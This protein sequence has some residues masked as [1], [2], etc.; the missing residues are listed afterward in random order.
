MRAHEPYGGRCKFTCV[1]LAKVDQ[2]VLCNVVLQ[3]HVFR[4][5]SST[6]VCACALLKRR[7]VEF[8]VRTVVVEL[9]VNF[10]GRFDC[11]EVQEF[12][13]VCLKYTKES[14]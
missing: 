4:S 2:L 11:V 8:A 13:R 6:V 1:V 7:V 5:A 10:D 3:S 14:S 12:L 9:R